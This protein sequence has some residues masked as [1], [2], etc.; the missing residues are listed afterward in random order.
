MLVALTVETQDLVLQFERRK[1]DGS[2]GLVGT[3][4]NVLMGR[5]T[6]KKEVQVVLFVRMV[7]ECHKKTEIATSIVV[8]RMAG[9]E[10]DTRCTS[11]HWIIQYI[12][13]RDI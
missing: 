5:T 6:S 11:Q 8:N 12:H 13:I 3:E 9:N 7:H 4:V 10:R 2:G 1:C